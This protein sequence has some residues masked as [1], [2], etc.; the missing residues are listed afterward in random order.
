[1]GWPLQYRV[2][3]P[4]KDEVRAHRAGAGAGDRRRPAHAARALRLDGAGARSCASRSTRTRRAS[5]ASARAALAA[6]LNAAD[7][8][9]RGHAGARRH[10]PGQRRGARRPTASASSFETLRVAA[11]A[12]AERAHGAAAAV[13]HLRRGAGVPAGLAP[14]PRADADGAR[15][16]R[17][18]ACCPTAWS[19]RWRR[20]SPSSAPKL[21][22]ALQGRDRRH[23]TRRAP[24]SQRLG[25]RGGAADDRADAAGDDGHAA[26]ASAAW[27]WWWRC[28]RSG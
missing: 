13:R 19:A 20:R 8:R 3:G 27:R 10:L 24:T 22:Q 18:A 2:S 23:C 7:H 25:V 6:V 21:P 12:H 15:R 28:C 11:G 1:M 5:S 16:R 14:R 4:D 17:P 9:H 26:S